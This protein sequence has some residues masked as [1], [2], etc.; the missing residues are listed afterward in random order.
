[1]KELIRNES[2][3]AIVALY[4][5]ISKTGNVYFKVYK[6]YRESFHTQE[7]IEYTTFEEATKTFI[8]WCE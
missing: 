7:S 8:L 1:M 5:G 3:A 4:A 2:K 6:S